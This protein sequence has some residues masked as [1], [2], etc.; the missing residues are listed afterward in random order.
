M[1]V[2]AQKVSGS[3]IAIA[4]AETSGV[5]VSE[6]PV[7]AAAKSAVTELDEMSSIRLYF[8]HFYHVKNR[9][10]SLWI[11]P[12]IFRKDPKGFTPLPLYLRECDRT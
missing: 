4:I 2:I 8:F 3:A 7:A 9:P 12:E 10:L 11:S 6:T 1:R 5:R